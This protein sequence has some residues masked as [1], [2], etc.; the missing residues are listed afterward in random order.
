[1]VEGGYKIK[2]HRRVKKHPEYLKAA[3]LDG[4]VKELIALVKKEPFGSPPPWKELRRDLKGFYSRR[5]NDK[6]RFVYTVDE[7]NKIVRIHSMWSHYE[8]LGSR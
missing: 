4:I 7:E 8:T 2:Y 6:H 5:I 3:K 1:M